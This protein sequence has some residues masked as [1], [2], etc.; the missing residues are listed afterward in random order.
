[1]AAFPREQIL[2]L[3]YEEIETSPA[4]LAGKVHR[5]LGIAARPQ[6]AAGLNAVNA[7]PSEGCGPPTACF[8]MLREQFAE[9]DRRL[10]SLLGLESDP[11]PNS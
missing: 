4:N 9:P 10:A 2:C 6:D 5:F 8:E 3:F 1:M 7:A 11:W